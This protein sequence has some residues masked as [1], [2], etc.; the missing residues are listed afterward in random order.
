MAR[1]R[2]RSNGR[3]AELVGVAPPGARCGEGG[4]IGREGQVAKARMRP[5]LVIVGNPS[6]NSGSGVIEAEEQGLVQELVPHAPVEALADA[7]LH[8]LARCDEVPGDPVLARP[9]KHGIRGELGAMVGNNHRRAAAAGDER[10]ELARDS[11]A[12][13]RRVRDRGQALLGDVVDDVEDAE[14]AAAGELIVHKVDRPACSAGPARAAAPV[15][16]WL[17]CALVG[18]APSV[19]PDDRAVASSCGSAPALPG[20]AG[21]A[22]AGSRRDAARPPGPIAD[23][24][25][26]DPDR[27]AR[28]P[29]AHLEPL[30]QMS[31]RLATRGGRQNFFASRSFSATLSSMASARFSFAF[32]SSS[33]FSRLASDTSRPPYFAFQA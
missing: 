17:A 20:A 8:R 15:L 5:A 29:L 13:D 22:G 28:P 26:V 19:L 25:A 18:A 6:R 7:V 30:P 4:G 1:W 21:R 14:A 24:P 3:T 16:R 27:A 12:R 9:A 33:A 32:S 2:R 31:D 10:C 11:L 23:R